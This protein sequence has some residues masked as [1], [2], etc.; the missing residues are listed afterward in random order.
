MFNTRKGLRPLFS[1]DEIASALSKRSP[2]G[3]S[4]G[5]PEIEAEIARRWPELAEV[6]GD[7]APATEGRSSTDS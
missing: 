6:R 2:G 5:V 3:L 1:L 7:V 4:F